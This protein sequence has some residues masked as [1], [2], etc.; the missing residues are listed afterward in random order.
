MMHRAIALTL[1]TPLLLGAKK[2]YDDDPLE[3]LLSIRRV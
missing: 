1:L 2:F 3:R